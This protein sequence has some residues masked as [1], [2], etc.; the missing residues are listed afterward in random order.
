MAEKFQIDSIKNSKSGI[1]FDL[2]NRKNLLISF[3]GIMHG[4]GI[5]V[6]EFFNI[7]KGIECD[8]IFLRDF[9]Q[10][11]YHNGIDENFDNIKKVQNLLEYYIFNNNYQKVCFLGNSMGGYASILFGVL[12]GIDTVISFAP[13]TFI[14]KWNRWRMKDSRWDQEIKNLYLSNNG[15]RKYFDLKKIISK[16]KF[17]EIN[18][19]YSQMD[20]LDKNHAERLRCM[21]KVILHKVEKGGHSV[22]KILKN[23]GQLLKIIENWQVGI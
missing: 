3:G 6:F 7:I 21:D 15:T 20:S 9:N 11:W 17:T 22:V 2:R 10:A 4:L 19:Y 16:N 1:L 5:P 14:D 23:N 12:I 8:K 18:I 13:Q